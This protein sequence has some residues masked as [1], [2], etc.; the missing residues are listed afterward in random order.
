[1]LCIPLYTAVTRPDWFVTTIRWLSDKWKAELMSAVMDYATQVHSSVCHFNCQTIWKLIQS[2]KGFEG[3]KINN[4]WNNTALVV[5]GE[6][7]KKKNS[8]KTLLEWIENV[9]VFF[10]SYMSTMCFCIHWCGIDYFNFIAAYIIVL[11]NVMIKV[12]EYGLMNMFVA[13]FSQM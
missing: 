5:S 1:M 9:S 6:V 3:G 2:N 4:T 12:T 10:P 7:F 11:L 8:K 13:N